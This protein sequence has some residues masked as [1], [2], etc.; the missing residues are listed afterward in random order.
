MAG[1]SHEIVTVPAAFMEALQRSADLRTRQRKL[2]E[3]GVA[4]EVRS[5]LK[6]KRRKL[7]CVLCG[8]RFLAARSDARYCSGRC[9][10]AA[11]RRRATEGASTRPG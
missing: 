8:G 7:L 1:V 2:V 11:H 3:A 4:V 5:H 10:V 9:R 6:L